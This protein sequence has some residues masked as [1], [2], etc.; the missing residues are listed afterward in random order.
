MNNEVAS[1]EEIKREFIIEYTFKGLDYCINHPIV[2]YGIC[3]SGAIMLT[4]I[5]IDQ[6]R[7]SKGVN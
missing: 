3:L 1:R 7:N 5:M 2:A 6:K 4:C